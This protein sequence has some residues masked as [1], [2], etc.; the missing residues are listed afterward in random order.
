MD[1][2]L[3]RGALF[4]LVTALSEAMDLVSPLVADHHRWTAWFAVHIAEEMGL[5]EGEIKEVLL[6]S[7]LHDVGAFSLRERLDT[8]NFDLENPHRHACLG[9]TLL[10]DCPPLKREALAILAHHTW[11]KPR[12]E[13]EVGGSQVPAAS[14]IIHLGD[15]VAI[16]LEEDCHVMDHARDILDSVAARAGTMFWPEAVDALERMAGDEK[17]WF[18]VFSPGALEY[19]GYKVDPR[20]MAMAP[21]DLEGL[22]G[23]FARVIDY[24]SHFTA[25]HSAGV[26]AVA[27]AL[28]GFLGFSEN[29][30]RT[31]RIAAHLHDLGKLAVPTEILEKR[32]RLDE[33]EYA[34]VR[35]HAMLT[36]RLLEKVPDLGYGLIWAAQHHERLD[37]SGYPDHTSGTQIAFGSRVV[38]MA[39]VFTALT[40]ERPYRPGLHR[41]EVLDVLSRLTERGRLDAEVFSV[42]RSR[43]DDLDTVRSAAQ[44][45]SEEDYT[46]RIEPFEAAVV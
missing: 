28:A 35:E 42:V 27:D 6:A 17:L 1:A 9:Y 30:R 33:M 37:G 13:T 38:A 41:K 12:S 5:E 16:L 29:N 2:H 24:R 21:G 3:S 40:E 31:M 34:H 18:G 32:H 4:Q 11:W 20:L 7:L 8:L 43:F 45:A 10:S 23:V 36:R 26:A 15:R 39:D 22:A 25:T 19:L 14:H 46:F 44:S